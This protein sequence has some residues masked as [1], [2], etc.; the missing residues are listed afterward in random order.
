VLAELPPTAGFL[1]RFSDFCELDKYSSEEDRSSGATWG[2]F[3]EVLGGRAGGGM[4]CLSF[5]DSPPVKDLQRRN[6]LKRWTIRK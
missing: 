1:E 4:A 3:L 2:M 6:T 5:D